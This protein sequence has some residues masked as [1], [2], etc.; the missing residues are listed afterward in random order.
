M[1][2]ETAIPETGLGRHEPPW[3][4]DAISTALGVF[5]LGLGCLELAAPRTITRHLGAE[6]H[7]DLVQAYGVRELAAGCGVLAT[8]GRARAPWMWSRVVGDVLDIATVASL[9]GSAARERGRVAQSV[10]L[11]AGV[12]VVDAYC[13]RRLGEAT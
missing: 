8:S 7:E 10:L 12:T 13:A 5:S 3:S 2:P 1:Y 4:S 11:L 9:G 6:G